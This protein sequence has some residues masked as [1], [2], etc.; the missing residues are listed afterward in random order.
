V[1]SPESAVALADAPKADP[2]AVA[3]SIN[4]LQANNLIA[5][6]HATGIPCLLVSGQNDP[7]ITI[8]E[9]DRSATFPTM[10]HHIVLEDAGHFPMVEDPL[11]FNRLMT[12]FMT[13]DSGVSPKELQLKEEW[14]RRVR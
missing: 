12:D 7:A 4:S 6:V 13:L 5:T 2:L 3:A 1:R 10:I 8:P 11:R 9:Q 14:R